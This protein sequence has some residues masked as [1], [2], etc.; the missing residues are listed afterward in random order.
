[1][2][3]TES[4]HELA[5]F[6]SHPEPI[7]SIKLPD[8]ADSKI[9]PGVLILLHNGES[10]ETL[11]LTDGTEWQ[12]QLT[13]LQP[14][15]YVV[16]VIPVDKQL[17]S[18]YKAFVVDDSIELMP[19]VARFNLYALD[20]EGEEISQEQL[21]V[22]QDWSQLDNGLSFCDEL[23]VQLPPN[24]TLRISLYSSVYITTCTCR[25]N[26]DGELD[27]LGSMIDLL[28]YLKQ[29][30]AVSVILDAGELGSLK[31]THYRESSPPI[32]QDCITELWSD[33]E[34]RREQLLTD[35]E[36]LTQFWLTPLFEAWGG[37]LQ[38]MPDKKLLDVAGTRRLFQWVTCEWEEDTVLAHHIPI[39][40][41]IE[42]MEDSLV[43]GGELRVACNKL[44]ITR[45]KRRML[46][47]DGLRIAELR[48]NSPLGLNWFDI[49]VMKNDKH[50]T[51]TWLGELE[52][53]A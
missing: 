53:G 23:L 16:Q 41:V 45:K 50:N 4:M 48:K 28:P 35:A 31:L 17:A 40:L 6:N 24:W 30:A 38:L 47:T 8:G 22:K 25:A 51:E 46:V 42:G 33:F 29:L 11:S 2:K 37:Q 52:G 36:L 7:L 3:T 21:F 20:H 18:E 27:L 14:G 43:S 34:M 12:F 19:T 26:E 39:L 5:V 9:K 44:L 10:S 32:V 15:T 49:E 1:M 13:D